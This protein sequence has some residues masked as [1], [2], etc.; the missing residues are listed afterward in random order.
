MDGRAQG[1]LLLAVGGVA[2]RLGVTDAALAYVKPGQ[3]P[4]LA[5]AGAVLLMLGAVTIRAALRAPQP[6]AHPVHPD[7]PDHEAHDHAPG[8]AWLLVLVVLAVLLV[9]PPPLGA[10]AA[11][12]QLAGASSPVRSTET[13]Y[14]PLPAPVDGAVELPLL[15]FT[16]RALYDE[17]RSLEGQRVRMTGFV[18]P[19][20]TGGYLLTRFLVGCCAAD[21]TPVTVAVHGDHARP[22]D[23]WLQVEGVWRP[24][25]DAA[26]TDPPVLDV[27]EVVE[28]PPPA[29][30][31]EY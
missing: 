14:P 25:P 17:K 13:N 16:I 20:A 3:R 31:Y 2:A 26:P 30:P 27:T 9:A 10:F 19:T 21:G 8:V 18:T 12:R 6:A 29:Q 5:A 1:A 15:D 22:A 4:L 7:H 23:T 24:T 28:V 11:G